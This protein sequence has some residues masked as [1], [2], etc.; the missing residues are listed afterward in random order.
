MIKSFVFLMLILSA[1]VSFALRCHGSLVEVGDRQETVITQCGEPKLKKV[2]STHQATYDA[3]GVQMGSVPF[4]TEEWLYQFTP[5]T[6]KYRVFFTNKK[7]TSITA[8][9]Q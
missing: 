4:L 5:Q 8:N 1:D 7:V 6:F 2:L 9:R 3:R